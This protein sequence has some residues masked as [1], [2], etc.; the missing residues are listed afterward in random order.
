MIPV[1]LRERY[2]AIRGRS[3]RPAPVWVNAAKT[4]LE[5]C[6]LWVVFLG[7][8]PVILAEMESL[9][10]TP[11]FRFPLW[12]ALAIF[13][14]S[15][16]V[17]IWSAWAFVV[18][19][20]GTPLPLDATNK[21]VVTGPYGYVRNPMAAGSLVQGLAVGLAWGSPFTVLYVMAGM[22]LW[23]CLARPWEEADLER[24]F[25]DEYRRY[26][27]SVRCWIPRPRPYGR[28]EIIASE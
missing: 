3:A 14:A 11:R 9:L 15:S 17:S 20:G 23:N 8:T 7:V 24:K 26:K 28:R 13:V 5:S 22:L 6:V 21:L 2:F 1:R 27:K 16:I 25:G 12:M 18:R 4:F 10:G 19:G